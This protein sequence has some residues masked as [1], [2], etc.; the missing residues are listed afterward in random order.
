MYFLITLIAFL[1]W[2]YLLAFR[3]GFWRVAVPNVPSNPAAPVSVA[4]VIPARNEAEGIAD[5]V[6]SLLAQDHPGNLRIVLVDDHST[7]G[8]AT[9]AREAAMRAGGAER[10]TIIDGQPLAEGWTGKLWAVSQGLEAA[11]KLKPDFILLTDADITHAPDNVSTLVRRMEH[12]GLDLASL[13]VRLSCQSSWEKALIPA[14]VF[15]FFMLYPPRW[16]ADPLARTAAAAGGCMLVRPEALEHIGGIAAIRGS[17]IDDCALAAAIKQ[18]GGMIRLDVTYDTFS[19]RLYQGWDE[20]WSMIARTAFT[21]LGYST[22]LLVGTLVGLFL[23]YMVPP[24][25]T[26][27]GHGW[28]RL[29]GIA[30]WAAMVVAFRPTLTL[31]GRSWAWGLAL[32]LIALFYAAATVG[33]AVNYWSGRGGQWKGRAQAIRH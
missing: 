27:F 6:T 4:V 24:L 1:S 26:I 12:D 3:G 19:T 28:T 31:Y 15:F 16:A 10:L 5:T 23:T 20:I 8:T 7:D 21:Q 22:L 18:S 14:F 2:L 11:N 30:A 25:A 33:S 17:L 29:F 13:M 9:I 32:P